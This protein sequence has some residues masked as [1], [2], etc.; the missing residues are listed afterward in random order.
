MIGDLSAIKRKRFYSF[1]NV[2]TYVGQADKLYAPGA[3]GEMRELVSEIVQP[4][5]RILLVAGKLKGNGVVIT[6]RCFEAAF[7]GSHE[8][9]RSESFLSP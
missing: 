8:I 7:Y 4:E 9:N 5:N 2:N 6:P 1:K 3:W